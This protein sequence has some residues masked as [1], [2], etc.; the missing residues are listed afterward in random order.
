MVICPPH[1]LLAGNL[2]NNVVQAIATLAAQTMPVLL[3]NYQGVGKSYKP[4]P[5]PLFEHWNQ[6]DLQ[7]DF[8]GVIREAK[9]VIRHSTRYFNHVH[10]VGYSFGAFI[11]H[12]CLTNSCHSYTVIAPPI[13]EHRFTPLAS[14]LPTLT[15]L[16]EMDSL[17]ISS[18]ALSLPYNSLLKKIKRAD[19]FFINHEDEVSA[20]IMEFIAA[21]AASD[22][23][24]Y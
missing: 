6:L 17:T 16:A 19:H 2:A 10:L 5:V 24:H 4:A 14:Q 9:D 21:T 8:S 13:V 18:P 1:P 20:L 7:N 23:A 12:H 3:F 22:S 11:A 15:I